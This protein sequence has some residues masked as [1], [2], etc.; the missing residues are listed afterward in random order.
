MIMPDNRISVRLRQ[1]TIPHPTESC[2]QLTPDDG[3]ED[4]S[5][6]YVTTFENVLPVA[7]DF[8]LDN[9]N[10]NSDSLSGSSNEAY[11]MKEYQKSI[12]F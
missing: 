8:D 11:E 6:S 4:K 9:V 12:T 7:A 3:A 1:R 2:L 5:S 10:A